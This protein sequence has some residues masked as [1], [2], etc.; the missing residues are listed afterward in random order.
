MT[1]LHSTNDV[2]VKISLLFSNSNVA[3]EAFP[4]PTFALIYY[5]Q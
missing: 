4:T 2:G 1:I 3:F 5:I